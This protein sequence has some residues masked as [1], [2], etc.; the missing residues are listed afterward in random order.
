[1]A[2]SR[3]VLTEEGD[4]SLRVSFEVSKAHA[5]YSL[6]LPA[7]YTSNERLSAIAPLPCLY[8]SHHDGSGLTL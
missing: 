1:M 5:W 6:S 7:A 2:L 4:M 8:T 3:N